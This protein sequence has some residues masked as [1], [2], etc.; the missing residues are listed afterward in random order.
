MN[1]ID[2]ATNFIRHYSVQGAFTENAL[3]EYPGVDDLD[4]A[5][6]NIFVEEVYSSRLVQIEESDDSADGQQTDAEIYDRS[7]T[8]FE[9]IFDR[10]RKIV[11]SLNDY[12]SYIRK[13][14]PPQEN[15]ERYLIP[16]AKEGNPAA[17]ERLIEMFLKIVVRSALYF[18]DRY[19]I[20]LYDA[21]QDGNS[22][23]IIALE[24][25]NYGGEDRFST[26]FPW[27][28]RQQIL[29][30]A[31]FPIED[32]FRLPV[33]VQDRLKAYYEE[34]WNA[35]N[36][37]SNFDFHEYVSLQEMREFSSINESDLEKYA[38]IFQPLIPYDTIDEYQLRSCPAYSKTSEWEIFNNSISSILN[39][40]LKS[41]LT[42]L[43][44]RQ[45]DVLRYRYGLYD[46]EPRT[47]EQVSEIYGVT[48]ERIRQIEFKA[49][50]LLR[51]PEVLQDL[52]G[53]I[54]VYPTSASFPV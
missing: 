49:L 21:I 23:L 43:S 28:V 25:F 36:F 33:H 32:K 4:L 8:D 38:F 22:G 5:Q 3:L 42:Q 53:F 27:W 6:Y 19:E 12:I 26:Y 16:L 54:D 35:L 7:Q 30:H 50:Q 41:A 9:P 10:V 13:I 45:A 37:K 52:K 24:K 14:K 18:Y 47:L 48:R 40:M 17:R 20:S 34:L 1:P 44:D 11:P 51:K 46:G 2:L 39:D 31:S 15:E 29:R